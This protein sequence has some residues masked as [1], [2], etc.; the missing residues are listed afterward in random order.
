M[1]AVAA[2]VKPE[3]TRH[4]ERCRIIKGML[5][6]PSIKWEIWKGQYRVELSSGGSLRLLILRIQMDADTDHGGKE[7]I[8]FFPVY[9]HTLEPIVIEDPVVDAFGGGALV[10]DLFIGLGTAGNIGI[11]TDIPVRPCFDDPAI[12][13]R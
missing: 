5:L 11:Q 8:V 2:W 7:R 10:I 3:T 9:H 13:G 12:S 6:R 4:M 1:E